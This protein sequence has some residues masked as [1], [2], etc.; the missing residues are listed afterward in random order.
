MCDEPDTRTYG[1][2]GHA[3][4]VPEVGTGKRSA[5]MHFTDDSKVRVRYDT[6]KA[7]EKGWTFSCEKDISSGVSVVYMHVKYVEW[8]G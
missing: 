3:P 4:A 2:L 8:E 7:V 6:S 1:G 5:L